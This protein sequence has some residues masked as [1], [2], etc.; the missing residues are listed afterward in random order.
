MYVQAFK[1]VREK[2][3]WTE[4]RMAKA[5]GVTPTHYRSLERKI[6]NPGKEILMK[7]QAIAEKHAKIDLREFWDLLKK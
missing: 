2:L 6:E 3:G 1:I 5:M 4:Y 7:F